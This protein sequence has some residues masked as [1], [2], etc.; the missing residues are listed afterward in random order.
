MKEELFKSNIDK[1][2]EL[3]EI[4]DMEMNQLEI[5]KESLTESLVREVR[6]IP[7][8]FTDATMS[9]AH[10]EFHDKECDEKTHLNFVTEIINDVVFNN[11]G[12]LYDSLASY[13]NT[14]YGFHFKYKGRNFEVKIPNVRVADSKNLWEMHYGKYSIYHEYRQ[15]CWEKVCENYNL[16][17]LKEQIDS[18][19]KEKGYDKD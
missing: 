18:Y 2:R 13:S 4:K 7:T 8:L 3:I 10:K 16:E 17:A 19:L 12:E 14:Y 1:Y 15:Y 11:E 9:K 5:I 6:K